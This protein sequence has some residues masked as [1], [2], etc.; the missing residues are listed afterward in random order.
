MMLECGS[1]GFD[2]ITVLDRVEVALDLKPTRVPFGRCNEV[3]KRFYSPVRQLSPLDRFDSVWRRS[4]FCNQPDCL[5]S[6]AVAVSYDGLASHELPTHQT[7]CLPMARRHHEFNLAQRCTGKSCRPQLSSVETAAIVLRS[8]QP[9][10]RASPRI[11]TVHEFSV[12]NIDEP[13]VRRRRSHFS[14]ALVPFAPALAFADSKTRVVSSCG[15][16]CRTP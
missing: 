6:P 9:V 5:Q 3:V 1:P 13:S 10:G 7:R 14:N 4:F 12:R 2:P 15:L 8:D 11:N 16:V